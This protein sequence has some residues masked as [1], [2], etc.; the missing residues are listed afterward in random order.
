MLLFD[1]LQWMD[2]ASLDLLRYLGHDWIRQ[3][4]RVLLL[5][6]VRSEGLELNAPLAAQLSDL[7]RDLPV[8][9]VSLQTLSQAETLQL[10][11]AV[12]GAREQGAAL[13]SAPGASSSQESERSLVAL[14]D[15]LFAHTGGNHCTCWSRSNCCATG[16]GFCH[17]WVPM[18]PG[19]WNRPWT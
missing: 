15:F 6:T 3:G 19:G 17:G 4:S 10:V 1:D 9:Q 5:L 12:A 13:P 2:G 16:N 14:G 7:G 18:A 8:S 11:Q